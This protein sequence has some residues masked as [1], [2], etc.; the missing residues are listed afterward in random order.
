MEIIPKFRSEYVWIGGNSVINGGVSIGSVTIIGS[1]S[2]VT[3]S[4][5]SRVIA[6]GNPCKVIREITQEDLV[7]WEQKKL[8]FDQAMGFNK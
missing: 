2:V 8:E 3:K 5:P 1:G 7:Y 6:A 4:I